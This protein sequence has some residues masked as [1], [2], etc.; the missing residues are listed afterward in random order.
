[1]CSATARIRSGSATD[2]PPN[3]CTSRLTTD[4][5]T[6]ARPELPAIP[7]RSRP[8]F[9][10]GRLP[11]RAQG[12]QTRAPAPEPGRPSSGDGGGREAPKRRMRTGRNLALLLIPLV[13][14]FVILQV[15]NSDDSDSPA[16]VEQR[17]Q[18]RT[19][20]EAP[21]DD[22][23]PGRRVHRDDRHQRRGR[24]SSALDA[25]QLPDV[26]QQLRVPRREASSTT[27]SRSTGSP[28]DFVDPGREPQQHHGPA[29]RVLGRR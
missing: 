6:G 10:V 20:A 9:A 29:A 18:R 28:Q 25:A 27:D 15:T 12:H 24:S 19:Y 26:G 3:F 23:R 5:G 17:H 11:R 16:S 4:D 8:S 14:V 22:D 13:I 7:L 21:A 2:V 1:M